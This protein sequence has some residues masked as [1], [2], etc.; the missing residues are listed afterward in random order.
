M[1]TTAIALLAIALMAGPAFASSAAERLDAAAETL[2]QIMAVRE[3]GIPQDLLARSEC[4]VLIPSSMKAGF[5]F[6]AEYGRGFFSCRT[7]EHGWSAPGAIRTEGASFGL[8]IGGAETDVVMLV[9]NR[10]GANRLLRDKFTLG[11]DAS[12]A[13]GPLGRDSQA[14]TDAFMTAEIL[15]YSR[16][17]GV[18]AGLSLNGATL[19]EDDSANREIYGHAIRNR[20]VIMNPTPIPPAAQRLIATLNKYSSRK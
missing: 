16:Q 9:L 17:R 8:Q 15:T 20:D 3:R 1:K 6:G 2:D 19:R 12:V 10:Q 14:A 13:A 7:P 5:V 4:I 11:G 18:F